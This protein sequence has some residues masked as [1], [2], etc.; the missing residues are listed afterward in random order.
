MDSA[1]LAPRDDNIKRT[2]YRRAIK[3]NIIDSN[4]NTMVNE[5]PVLVESKDSIAAKMN[6]KVIRKEKYEIVK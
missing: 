5:S 3:K 6:K 2:L 4:A 1:K